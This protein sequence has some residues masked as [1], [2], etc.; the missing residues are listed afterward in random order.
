MPIVPGPFIQTP[1]GGV[2]RPY[3]QKM[4]DNWHINDF[5]R[6]GRDIH[7]SFMLANAAAY[8][9]AVKYAKIVD[10]DPVA[11]Y[12]EDTV[13]QGNG[14]L[15]HPAEYTGVLFRGRGCPGERLRLDLQTT[16]FCTRIVNATNNLPILWAV[17]GPYTGGGVTGVWFDG[18]AG[19]LGAANAALEVVRLTSVQNGHWDFAAGGGREVQLRRNCSEIPNDVIVNFDGFAARGET[20][21]RF[22]FIIDANEYLD[23]QASIC[24]IV[25]GWTDN[26]PA[27]DPCKN[28]YEGSWYYVNGTNNAAKLDYS[29]VKGLENGRAGIGRVLGFVDSESFGSN[30]FQIGGTVSEPSTATSILTVA[31]TPDGDSASYP[32]HC[33]FGHV[34]FQNLPQ[35]TDTTNGMPGGSFDYDQQEVDQE[36][37][38][39]YPE[40]Y[41]WSGIKPEKVSAPAPL[42]RRSI[43]GLQDRTRE[44]SNRILNSRFICR[45]YGDSIIAPTNGQILADGGIR[46]EYDGALTNLRVDFEDVA[47]DN[48]IIPFNPQ[49]T[50]RIRYSGNTATGLA[51]VLPVEDITRFL[52]DINNV[53]A[54]AYDAED[55]G[56]ISSLIN[57]QFGTGGSSAVNVSPRNSG[58]YTGQ[59]S[60]ALTD[61][62][63]TRYRW[64]FD[65]PNSDTYVIGP[66]NHAKVYIS[67]PVVG[68]HD[69]Y[70]TWPAFEGGE[71]DTQ[72]YQR[73]PAEVTE[74]LKRYTFP[75][76]WASDAFLGQGVTLSVGSKVQLWVQ[77]PQEMVYTPSLQIKSGA[78]FAAR[79]LYNASQFALTNP[80]IKWAD[81]RAV[82]IEFDGA[83]LLG[84]AAPC[85]ILSNVV[86]SLILSAQY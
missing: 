22:R 50:M 10:L 85:L 48:E 43:V 15:L 2:P 86:N 84:D 32:V 12:L 25:D 30:R 8:E 7:D 17:D 47:I 35:R 80:I 40:N 27:P 44:N 83:G 58:I 55:G 34:Q 70:I 16:S 81:N 38:A 72:A 57:L 14:D 69:I 53:N 71:A 33:D 5:I 60:Q 3:I 18:G 45:S 39:T 36:L 9:D 46:L 21:N 63:K 1:E 52:G 61:D 26:V 74:Y 51:L 13:Y 62:P 73:E 20:A 31:V 75:L 79:S 4:R 77:L 66:R 24:E 64:I 29:H 82:C 67:L 68:D 19:E 59:Q 23:G 76:P 56:D 6:P 28:I 41:Y 42:N 54:Y 78:T 37:A 65:I 11:Y 49:R